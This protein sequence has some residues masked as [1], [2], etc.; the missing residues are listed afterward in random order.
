MEA[1][2]NPRII[3]LLLSSLITGLVIILVPPV[4]QDPGYHNFAD[5]RNFSGIP[6]FWNVVTNIPFLVLGITGFFKI[7]NQE[8]RGVLPDL[9]KAYLTF[10]MGLVLTGLGSGYDH[11]DPSNSTLVGDRMAITI[12]FMSFFVLIIGESISTRTASRFLVPLLFLG[13]AS[14]VYWNITE[15]LGTGDLRFYALVQFLP[16]LLI[17]LML[18]FYGSCLSGRRWILAIILVYGAAKIA[19]MYDQQIYELI[20]FSGHSLK[21]LIAAFGAFLFLKGLEVRKPIK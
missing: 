20:G 1:I 17:P 3:L 16:M 2:I 18:L 8:L 5:Q 21:H 6:H 7:Q 4:S 9:F 12:S 14:V 13:L 19:E 11:L 10:F 15:N